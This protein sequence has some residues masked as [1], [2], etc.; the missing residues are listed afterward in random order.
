MLSKHATKKNWNH[1]F[2]T[3][4]W[5]NDRCS[6]KTLQRA[7][8]FRYCFSIL[9]GSF[10]YFLCWTIPLNGRKNG[11]FQFGS[12]GIFCRSF[13]KYFS[14]LFIHDMRICFATCFDYS[15]ACVVQKSAGKKCVSVIPTWNF[16]NT[17]QITNI[18]A[19][20]LCSRIYCVGN[21]KSVPEL[22]VSSPASVE[23][24]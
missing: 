12:R 23:K 18:F 19:N 10:F 7:N 15:P 9:K 22:L 5:N 6:V 24:P 16:L 21:Y 2:I 17:V 3:S 4:K 14:Q 13:S 11:T 8:K 1:A 20:V